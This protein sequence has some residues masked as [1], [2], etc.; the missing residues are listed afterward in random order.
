MKIKHLN[1]SIDNIHIG[2]TII[3]IE[4][5]SISFGI[6]I[7]IIPKE[8]QVEVIRADGSIILLNKNSIKLFKLIKDDNRN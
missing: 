6:L 5:A 4:G 7:K 2:K 3:I 8:N 1:T